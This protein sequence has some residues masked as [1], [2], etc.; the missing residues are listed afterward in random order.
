MGS[1]TLAQADCDFL[2]DEGIGAC[3]DDE[4]HLTMM[5]SLA[6]EVGGICTVSMNPS[7]RAA[8]TRALR[9][10]AAGGGEKA[11]QAIAIA[12]ALDTAFVG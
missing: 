2:R 6:S 10:L 5:L 7:E 9:D 3:F 1:I 11:Q 8:I 4:N 12:N